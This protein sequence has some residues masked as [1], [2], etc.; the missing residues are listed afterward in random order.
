MENLSP[1]LGKASKRT[2]ASIVMEVVRSSDES[3]DDVSAIS[4]LVEVAP[5]C[6]AAQP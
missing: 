1:L 3:E 6:S 2:H 4:Y 5:G